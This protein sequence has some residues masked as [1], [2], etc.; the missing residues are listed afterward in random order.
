MAAFKVVIDWLNDMF[1]K[2]FLKITQNTDLFSKLYLARNKK[3]EKRGYSKPIPRSC[4]CF[5]RLQQY[6]KD[7]ET[8]K[9]D[10][11]I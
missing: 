9:K 8:A 4:D 6:F 3:Q 10:R 7:R 5:Q 2:P 11:M 1:V